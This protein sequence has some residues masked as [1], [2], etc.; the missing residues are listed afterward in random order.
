VISSTVTELRQS[1]SPTELRQGDA[2]VDWWSDPIGGEEAATPIAVEEHVPAKTVRGSTGVPLVSGGAR[3]IGVWKVRKMREAAPR[4]Y[5]DDVR[6]QVSVLWAEDWDSD[7][8][9]VYDNDEW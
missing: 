2:L 7:E 4:T 8:D 1:D 3:R 6:A 5:E 9:A